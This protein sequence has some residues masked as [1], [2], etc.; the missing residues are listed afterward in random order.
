M[1][2][3]VLHAFLTWTHQSL[4]DIN[5]IV[6]CCLI[7]Y[8]TERSH[9]HFGVFSSLCRCLGE[10]KQRDDTPLSTPNCP[11]QFG[12]FPVTSCSPSYIKCAGGA[13]FETPCDTGT[14]YDERIHACN[15]P[16]QVRLLFMTSKRATYP[17]SQGFVVL[18]NLRQALN[19]CLQFECGKFKSL[20]QNEILLQIPRNPASL[21]RL[22][23]LSVFMTPK[24]TSYIYPATRSCRWPF[25]FISCVNR[26]PS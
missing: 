21:T 24:K 3:I 11:Y 1:R 16:D 10:D 15:W 2:T 9:Y 22:I 17:M 7:I 23:Y 8:I 12:I 18:R 13:A 14:V 19:L 20:E 4:A 26:C 25:T 6:H 5:E